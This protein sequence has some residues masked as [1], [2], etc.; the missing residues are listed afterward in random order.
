MPALG[1][2]Q[3][4]DLPAAVPKIVP[5]IEIAHSPAFNTPLL[6]IIMG[7]AGSGK[8]TVGRLLAQR[9]DCDYLEGDRRHPAANL[10]KMA[11]GIPL[12]ETDRQVW[13]SA[14]RQDLQW[15]IQQQRETVVAC[16]GLRYAHRQ[17]LRVTPRVQLVWLQV[18]ESLLKQRLS[19]RQGH[20]LR[21]ELLNSQLA[22]AEPMQPDEQVLKLDGALTASELVEEL[23][24]Q[25]SLTWSGLAHPWWE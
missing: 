12:M 2:G 3:R 16:S 9:R 8:T 21:L 19:Q 20:Y 22:T 18:P 5:E 17:Q 6:W 23:L 7:V 1:W 25:A 4:V 24:T 14:L 10:Q 11:A 15:A 13:L